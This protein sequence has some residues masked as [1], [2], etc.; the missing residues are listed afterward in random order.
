VEVGIGIA[1]GL[2]GVNWRF[3]LDTFSSWVMTMVVMGLGTGLMF[4]QGIMIHTLSGKP[5]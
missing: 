4:A 3:F 2:Q 1:E 5:D